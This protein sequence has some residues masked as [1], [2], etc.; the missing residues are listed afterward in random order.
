MKRTRHLLLILR[1]ARL[2][3]RVIVAVHPAKN[4]TS[5]FGNYDPP[6]LNLTPLSYSAELCF[7]LP[8]AQ[9][10]E[11][12]ELPTRDS[13]SLVPNQKQCSSIIPQLLFEFCP[14]LINA[15]FNLLTPGR[16]CNDEHSR[17]KKRKRMPP[18][19]LYINDSF[20]LKSFLN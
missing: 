7:P 3:L 19:L 13:T 16:P 8:E 12:K 17:T 6:A 4:F 9:W 14:I 18:I 2:E 1:G 20:Y 10:Y 15:Y 11:I 5:A